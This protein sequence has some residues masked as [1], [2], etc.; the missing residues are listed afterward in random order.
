M[1]VASRVNGKPRKSSAPVAPPPSEPAPHEGLYLT[2][3]PT[4]KR[5][6]KHVRH[7][8][9]N[10]PHEATLLDQWHAA[11]RIVRALEKDE[12]GVADGPR[13]DQLGPEYTPLL[14]ELLQ[15]PLI[16]YGFNTVP[17]EVALV[18]LEQMVVYQRHIDLTFVDQLDATLPPNP[19]D[20]DVFRL[21]LPFN[22]P[23]PRVE[24]SRSHGD[25]FTFVSPSNDLRYLGVMPL[26]ADNITDFP[27][28]GSL[29]GV[30]GIAVGFGS[31][32]LNALLIEGRLILRN[33][34]HRAYTLYRRGIKRVP[35]IVQ[36]LS[37]RDELDVVGADE[38]H[39]R[40]DA[41]LKD[42]RPSMLKDY[43]NPELRAA[44]MVKRRLHTVT[45][46]FNVEQNVMPAL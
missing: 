2:G 38:V 1:V 25:K 16:R 22:H 32:F 10:P 20:A 36:H 23:Q 24:W 4:L 6:L 43:L 33:G 12:A 3:R 9:A 26:E 37:A 46:A 40:P 15:D 41:Y 39:S 8:A 21:C 13:I 28:P 5:F 45:V 17:T 31:N 27:P 30:I 14:T 18:D 34:S 29:V 11:N 44:L 35:C 42:R 19:S 7:H